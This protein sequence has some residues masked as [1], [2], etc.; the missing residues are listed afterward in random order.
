VELQ[1]VLRPVG[2]WETEPTGYVHNEK[3]PPH[4]SLKKK[5]GGRCWKS[6][7]EKKV[8]VLNTYII[9]GK[10]PESNG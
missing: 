7:E 4:P 9:K 10:R 8:R 5:G 1:R 3:T 2:P 6:R